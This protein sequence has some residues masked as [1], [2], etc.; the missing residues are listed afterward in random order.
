MSRSHGGVVEWEKRAD[1]IVKQVRDED[2]DILCCQEVQDEHLALEMYEQ[3]KD[4][5]PHFF[6]NFGPHTYGSNI[7]LFIACK[8]PPKDLEFITYRDSIGSAKWI[9]K[10]FARLSLR[11]E[12]GKGA[13]IITSNLQHAGNKESRATREKQLQQM[14]A[15]V[16]SLHKDPKEKSIPKFLL[17][18]L[19][20]D[21]N[22]D[23]I[24]SSSLFKHF[25]HGYKSSDE[26]CSD[27]LCQ[28][29][30]DATDEERKKGIKSTPERIDYISLLTSTPDGEELPV[31]NAKMYVHRVLA[32]EK[33]DPSSARSDHHAL[34]GMIRV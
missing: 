20:V 26:T 31:E 32:Y 6:W 7:G 12:S 5:Y 33:S 22:T 13:D 30:W 16:Q 15:H 18:D 2:P 3:L 17:G 34:S 8:F 9:H 25:R 14:L 1:R 4:V 19:N 29:L 23:E 11:D 21:R 27:F 10:G 24:E 28:D